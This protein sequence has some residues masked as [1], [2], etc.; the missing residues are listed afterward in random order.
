LT[1]GR[2]DD[3]VIVVPNTY[4]TDFDEA[5]GYSWSCDITLY[6]NNMMTVG[7]FTIIADRRSNFP[8]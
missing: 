1:E 4:F 7:T 6:L 3:R 5:L 2:F 8:G